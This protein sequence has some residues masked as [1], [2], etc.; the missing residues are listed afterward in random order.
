MNVVVS[1]LGGVVAGGVAWMA[2]RGV[3]DSP[4]LGRAN[5]RGVQ[6]PTA[7]GIVIVAAVL[8]VEGVR[9]LV[10]ERADVRVLVAVLA[11]AVLGL[12]DDVL[13]SGADGRGFKGHLRAMLGGRL[14][15]GGLKLLG[16]LVVAVVFADHVVDVLLIAACANLG[17]LFDRAPGRTL[18]VA[19]IAG[20]ALLVA[21]GAPAELAGVAAV[22]GASL[23][24]LPADLG[25]RIMIGDTGANAVGGVL[26][27]GVVLVAPLSV[28][29]GVL[30][31]VVA[32]N[33]L[34]E[35]VSFSRVI[36]ATPPLRA[37]DRLGR[38]E[39]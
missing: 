4:V 16:G 30:V 25:E 19:A 20:G 27:L 2:L 9:R 10:D 23:A 38:R 31:V 18:K 37:I 36:D 3:L 17:N 7:G 22:L 26:G 1:L 6:V 15:T 13:G 28:R 34:S 14:T 29:L 5:H 21:A 33:L 35:V 24:L 39:R 11:F 32:L 12:V 8:A